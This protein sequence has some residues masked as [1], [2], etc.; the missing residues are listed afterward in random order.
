MSKL[1]KGKRSKDLEDYRERRLL[2]RDFVAKYL[3]IVKEKWSDLEKIRFRGEWEGQEKLDTKLDNISREEVDEWVSQTPSHRKTILSF[4]ARL[5]SFPSFSFIEA[6]SLPGNRDRPD[7]SHV[8]PV[9]AHTREEL[10]GTFR[11]TFL[12]PSPQNSDTDEDDEQTE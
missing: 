8:N 9:E 12:D 10:C 7:E 6:R 1:R 4:Y 3:K 2:V 5:T 11:W